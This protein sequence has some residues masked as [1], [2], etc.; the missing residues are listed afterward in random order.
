MM[1]IHLNV[2]L[3]RELGGTVSIL[4]AVKSLQYDF[5]SEATPLTFFSYNLKIKW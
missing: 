3:Q 4:K 2:K 1:R 5:T